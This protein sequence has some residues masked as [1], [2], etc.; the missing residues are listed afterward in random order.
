M[1][2][3]QKSKHPNE[4]KTKQNPVSLQTQRSDAFLIYLLGGVRGFLGYSGNMFLQ[5]QALSG[6]F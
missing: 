3:N 4:A 2:I 5:N 6:C 1:K